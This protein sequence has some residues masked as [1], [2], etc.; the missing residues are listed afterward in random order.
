VQLRSRCLRCKRGSPEADGA[1][2]RNTYRCCGFD[3]KPLH[4][5]L[6][7]PGPAIRRLPFRASGFVYHVAAVEVGRRAGDAPV[8]GAPSAPRTA[9]L[10]GSIPP[11]DGWPDQA[12]GHFT[13]VP[14]ARIP[15]GR[16][17]STRPARAQASAIF[18]P[19]WRCSAVCAGESVRRLDGPS[20]NLAAWAAESAAQGHKVL[21]L[22]HDVLSILVSWPAQ[23]S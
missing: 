8:L 23:R 9:V 6:T 13:S 21:V 1:A 16:R 22:R 10:G 15:A 2:S 19:R 5:G 4:I 12:E 20:I 11:R 14:G 17:G 18:L 7:E 3:C